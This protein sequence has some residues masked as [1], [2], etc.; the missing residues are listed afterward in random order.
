MGFELHFK[1]K[2]APPKP[3]L[4]LT[5]QQAKSE[6][7]KYFIF[8]SLQ[9]YTL[10]NLYTFIKDFKSKINMLDCLAKNTHDLYIYNRYNDDQDVYFCGWE[11]SKNNFENEAEQALSIAADKENEIFKTILAYKSDSED[12]LIFE[13]GKLIDDYLDFMN[14]YYTYQWCEEHIS[15]I[16]KYEDE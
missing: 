11:F 10:D 15:E 16:V 6:V 3:F 5:V 9:N 7:I 2:D 14:D 8:H 12:D 1:L 13:L 4:S